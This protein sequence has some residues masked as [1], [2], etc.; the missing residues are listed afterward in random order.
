[1]ATIIEK[2]RKIV[3]EAAIITEK[4]VM[5]PYLHDETP[6][7]KGY[8]EAV[9]LPSSTDEVSQIM[10]LANRELIAI[11]PRGGGTGLS[12]GAVPQGGIVLSLEKLNRI[13]DI[14]VANSVAVVEP[15]VVTGTLREEVEKLNLFYPPDPASLDSC[16]IGGNIAEDAGGAQTL[17][18]GTTKNYVLG[19]EVVLPTGEVI[20]TG[21]KLMKNATGYE[22]MHLFIGSEGTL[23]VVTKAILKLI[24]APKYRVDLLIPFTKFENLSHTVLDILHKHG[25]LPAALEFMEAKAIKASEQ[26][27]GEKLPFPEAKALL[28]VELD[29]NDS[30][31]LAKQYEVIGEVAL[32]NDAID[33]LVAEDERRR[34]DLWRAR[35][36][37]SEALKSTG[38]VA[39]E[40]V[41][42]P[43][44]K[45]PEL[46]KYIE[47]LESTY[48]LPIAV[49][50]HIG[51][52]NLHVNILKRGI[53]DDV[54]QQ[55]LP[56][57]VHALYSKVVSVGG[58]ISG[59]HG[60]GLA[61][62]QYLSMS[63][64]PEE[65]ALMRNMK[66]MLDPN[67]ILNPGKVL[68]LS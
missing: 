58:K 21:G 12:G 57:L 60:I 29:G 23:G 15:G 10:E 48:G 6:G 5:E 36:V 9:V 49:Y 41:V 13:L 14:D 4:D 65:I 55:R 40:D 50:G 30:D 62:R 45:I 54:W 59:E 27:T 33:V 32:N 17:K 47:Q 64:S 42:V 19:L 43:R 1:M 8:A 18:Y 68:D 53:P 38:E 34:A 22:L 56:T 25:I 39:H 26:H 37:I 2:L 67:N 63:V 20:F 7:L 46:L 3:E 44:S 28:L 52:G 35:R 24:P 61:K 16:T 66:R 11:T 51:D 31:L